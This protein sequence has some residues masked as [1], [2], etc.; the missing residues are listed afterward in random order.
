MFE[1]GFVI[2]ASLPAFKQ[3]LLNPGQQLISVPYDSYAVVAV[4]SGTIVG[5]KALTH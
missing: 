2:W 1:A 4:R 5:T 3:L